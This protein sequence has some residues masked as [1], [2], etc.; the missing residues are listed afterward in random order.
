MTHILKYYPDIPNEVGA[1]IPPNTN[2]YSEIKKKQKGYYLKTY[3]PETESVAL[4]VSI[5][6]GT[7]GEKCYDGGWKYS[8]SFP[9]PLVEIIQVNG[10]FQVSKISKC[11]IVVCVNGERIEHFVKR[12]DCISN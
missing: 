11:Y 5:R 12:T 10:N 9:I 3:F 6:T 8:S 4:T 2:I 7:K 1:L